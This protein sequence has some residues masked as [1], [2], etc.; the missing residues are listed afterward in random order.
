MKLSRYPKSINSRPL[1]SPL[2]NTAAWYY[3]EKN[4]LLV[5]SELRSPDGVYLGTVQATIPLH[6]IRDYIKRL[7]T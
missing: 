1:G 7:D 6:Q 4:R 3:T 2:G 5:V